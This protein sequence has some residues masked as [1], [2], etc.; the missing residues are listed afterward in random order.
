[1][2]PEISEINSINW[3]LQSCNWKCVIKKWWI[4]WLRWLK[5]I[6]NSLAQ[7]LNYLSLISDAEC[8]DAISLFMLC[9]FFRCINGITF[10][11]KVL[12]MFP[13]WMQKWNLLLDCVLFSSLLFKYEITCVSRERYSKFMCLMC[14]DDVFLL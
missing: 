13:L 11:V 14:S 10:A 8:N 4:C 1:M 9:W 7:M 6:W 3:H 2:Y 12:P 5:F